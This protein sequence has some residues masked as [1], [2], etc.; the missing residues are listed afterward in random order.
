MTPTDETVLRDLDTRIFY[1]V[2]SVESLGASARLYKAEAD[3]LRAALTTQQQEHETD[4]KLRA[5]AFFRGR[6]ALKAQLAKQQRHIEALEGELAGLT[7]R[8]HA[9]ET[10]TMPL[11]KITPASERTS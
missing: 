4:E 8:L 7:Q 6:E 11:P 3:Q 5:D 1:A 10:G 2:S 9:Y